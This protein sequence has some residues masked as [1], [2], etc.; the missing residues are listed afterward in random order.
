[1]QYSYY[2]PGAYVKVQGTFRPSEGDQ[3]F[4]NRVS[5]TLYNAIVGIIP[6]GNKFLQ[7]VVQLYQE[8][9]D[10]YGLL[11]YLAYIGLPY[12]RENNQG[13]SPAWAMGVTPLAYALILKAFVTTERM[14]GRNDYSNL[15]ITREFIHR[16]ISRPE[17]LAYALTLSTELAI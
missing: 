10:G 4:L 9:Q 17:Y 16:A 15:Q 14:S 13:W 11:K 1:M 5:T 12:M 2:G 3:S 6:G 8:K 7:E